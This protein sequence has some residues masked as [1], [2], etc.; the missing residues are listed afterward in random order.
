MGMF[1]TLLCEYELPHKEMQDRLFQ[2]KC[3]PAQWCD[4]YKIDAN[5]K[6]WHEAYEIEDKSDPKA[7][8]FERFAGMGTKVN[9][10]WEEC[11]YDG[12]IYF[13]TFWNEGDIN[14]ESLGWIEYQGIFVDGEMV[15][16]KTYRHENPN[17]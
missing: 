7:K 15:E 11:K 4:L 14:C 6:L 1:D 16:L 2:T 8:G 3:T 12:S 13:Y 9:K 10:R 5:G 17:A